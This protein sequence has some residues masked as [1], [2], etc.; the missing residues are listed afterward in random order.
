EAEERFRIAS[1][2]APTES[3]VALHYGLFL[4]GEER[5]LEA[6]LQFQRSCSSLTAGKYSLAED[7]TANPL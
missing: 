7:F 5:S 6:G 4:L 3:S 1:Q 2:I